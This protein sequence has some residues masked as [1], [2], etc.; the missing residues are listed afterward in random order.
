MADYVYGKE[1]NVFIQEAAERFTIGLDVLAVAEGEGRNAAY[2]AEQGCH[3]TIW[4]YAQSGLEKAQ[5]LANEKDVHIQTKLQDLIGADWQKEAFNTVICIFGHFEPGLRKQTLE[6]IRKTV[7]QGGLFITEVY[8]E[9]QLDYGIGG[10]KDVEFLYTK[11]DFDVFSDWETLHFEKKEVERH[12]GF[13]HN[14]LACVI[15]YIGR[16]R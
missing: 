15:Q 2:L 4:D 7:K 13:G 3:V 14:G 16:K 1:A 5:V 8:A 11:A 10:L 12:E 6:G 9:E